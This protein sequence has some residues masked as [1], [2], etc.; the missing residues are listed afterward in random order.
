M[1]AMQ[2][3]TRWLD[4]LGIVRSTPYTRSDYLVQYIHTALIPVLVPYFILAEAVNNPKRTIQFKTIYERLTDPATE[5]DKYTGTQIEWSQFDRTDLY[6]VSVLRIIARLSCASTLNVEHGC[7]IEQLPKWPGFTNHRLELQFAHDF[8]CWILHSANKARMFHTSINGRTGL[9]VLQQAKQVL[10]VTSNIESHIVRMAKEQ[11][12]SRAEQKRRMRSIATKA[13]AN[14]VM[15]EELSD[16]EDEEDV[17]DEEREEDEPEIPGEPA[18]AAKRPRLVGDGYVFNADLPTMT[19][20]S[21]RHRS[22]STRRTRGSAVAL[23]LHQTA[24]DLR[25][26]SLNDPSSRFAAKKARL[27]SSDLDEALASPYPVRSSEESNKTRSDSIE[28]EI[29]V[30]NSTTQHEPASGY[31]SIVAEESVNHVRLRTVS[32]VGVYMKARLTT[33]VTKKEPATATSTPIKSEAD[34]KRDK[35][36]KSVKLE[37]RSTTQQLLELDQDIIALAQAVEDK[38]REDEE[39]ELAIKTARKATLQ[40]TLS[41]IQ[42]RIDLKKGI[43]QEV[44]EID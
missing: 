19:R 1:L 39:V 25:Y 43:K 18:R 15:V 33:A 34:T 14:K 20:E 9:Q 7:S 31:H 35:Y 38:T 4:L 29:E 21:T 40:R 42:G 28:V 22:H 6:C 12:G 30:D 41:K 23:P 44:I 3:W 27:P 16:A 24:K 2:S 5:R 37:A 26:R 17:V 32:P 36:E 8:L 13:D 11:S 10:L